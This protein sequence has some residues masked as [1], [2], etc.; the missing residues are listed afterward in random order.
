MGFT[1]AYRTWREAAARQG[2]QRNIAVET[3][4]WIREDPSKQLLLKA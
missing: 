3:Y 4:I 1:T 2:K